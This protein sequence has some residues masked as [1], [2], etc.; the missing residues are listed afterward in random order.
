MLRAGLAPLR[1]L[2]AVVALT[3]LG[4]TQ[5]QAQVDLPPHRLERVGQGC[6]VTLVPASMRGEGPQ[7]AVRSRG[8]QSDEIQIGLASANGMTNV[9]LVARNNRAAFAAT[10]F[11]SASNIRSGQVW[12]TLDSLARDD[13]PF[14]LTGTMPDGTWV[15]ARYD[16]IN[17]LGI[18]RILET[19]SCYSSATVTSRT[20]AEML[21]EEQ[22][23][24][25]SQDNVRHIR[26]VLAARDAP[27]TRRRPTPELA[28]A[29]TL[30][31]RSR[32]AAYSRSIGAGDTRYLTRD[33]ANRL[34]AVPF[35][36]VR[37]DLSSGMSSF[38]QDRAW[39]SYWEPV[40]GSRDGYC[41]VA[42]VAT[43]VE[44]VDL[45]E[46]PVMYIGAR[47]DWSGGSAYFNL[48]HPMPFDAG[49]QVY[50]MVD[51]SRY[52]LQIDDGRVKPRATGGNT[53]SDDVIRAIRRGEDIRIVG[54]SARTGRS[55]TVR[56]SAF[57]FTSS[58]NR[59]ADLCGRRQLLN[60]LN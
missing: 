29:L 21:A 17:P 31:D 30:Q 48:V 46:L 2:G 14:H 33:L 51:G 45:W 22:A 8:T 49:R 38:M 25:L 15:S 58:F 4:P 55:L 59:M 16:A 52:S 34:L 53:V 27:A 36:P 42:S 12:R 43:S 3:V 26:W 11:S 41:T 23:L 50:A 60:W 28:D 35:Y 40:S 20:T 13:L 10:T 6:V 7:L 9:S 57:G 32:L 54:T 39:A 5:A 47:S 19:N 24:R 37:P 44:G 18:I 1:V 56:F